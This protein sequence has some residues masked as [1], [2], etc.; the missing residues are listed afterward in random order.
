MS[1]HA[2]GPGRP[3]TAAI[4]RPTVTVTLRTNA[5]AGAHAAAHPEADPSTNRGADADAPARRDANPGGAAAARKH[6]AS[7][8]PWSA[9]DVAARQ[10]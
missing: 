8:G 10:R 2:I 4:H 3:T 9:A 6:A 7:L 1:F 5:H